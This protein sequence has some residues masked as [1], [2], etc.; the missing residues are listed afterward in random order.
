MTVAIRIIGL[1]VQAQKTEVEVATVEVLE[2][3]HRELVERG[4]ASSEQMPPD[5]DAPW[6][7]EADGEDLP[8]APVLADE[9]LREALQNL[10]AE[11]LEPRQAQHT[12]HGRL[13]VLAPI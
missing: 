8:A 9:L 1:F 13:A 7:D 10:Q 12:L 2:A 5:E 4:Q 11:P 6:D 3:E